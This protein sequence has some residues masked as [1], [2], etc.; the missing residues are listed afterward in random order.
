MRTRGLV[1]GSALL[2]ALS[3][4]VLGASRKTSRSTRGS[5]SAGVTETGLIGRLSRHLGKKVLLRAKMGTPRDVQEYKE[6]GKVLGVYGKTLEVGIGLLIAERDEESQEVLFW[7]KR[8][9]PITVV[10]TVKLH[11]N[12]KRPYMEVGE[13]RKGWDEAKR[14]PMCRGKGYVAKR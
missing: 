6:G 13:L 4:G 5:A 14:C 8:G 12:S 2:A 1:F 10:G 7:A 11:A 3:L 9:E